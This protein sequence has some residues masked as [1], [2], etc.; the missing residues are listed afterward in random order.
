MKSLKRA[1]GRGLSLILAAIAA[2]Y[3]MF[4]LIIAHPLVRYRL[5]REQHDV[6]RTVIGR[7]ALRGCAVFRLWGVRVCSNHPY[8][9]VPLDRPVIVVSSHHSSLDMV[10]LLGLLQNTFGHRNLRF[11]S[12]PGLDKG[13]PVISQ[14]IK[15]Y[16]YSLSRAGR[17]RARQQRED[18]IHMAEFCQRMN[19]ENGVV[20][21]F[22]EGVKPRGQPEHSRTFIRTGLSVMLE[23]MP[24]AIVLPLVIKGT[25]EF[26]STP[27]RWKHLWRDFPKFG[28]SMEFSLLPAL[29]PR[30]YRDP[31]ALI[32]HCESQIHREYARLRHGKIP[33]V[34]TKVP[35]VSTMR[36]HEEQA[37]MEEAC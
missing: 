33:P 37:E 2:V 22:P 28:V 20:T 26:Y 29:E 16:C 15:R 23:N 17:F 7:W 10:F 18:R 24:D 31:E 9:R 19:A 35:Q 13:I 30:D 21:I 1:G 4:I 32:S 34:V 14:Y 25:G 27:R 5:S 36:M 12:R 6:V 11:V 8:V 3:W